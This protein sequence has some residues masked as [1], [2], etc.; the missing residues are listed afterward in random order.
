MCEY[1]SNINLHLFVP[2]KA[3]IG[4]SI[5]ML[6]QIK[7]VDSFQLQNFILKPSNKNKPFRLKSQ[8][9]HISSNPKLLTLNQIPG[10][11]LFILR[12]QLFHIIYQ[13]MSTD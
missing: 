7:Y 8:T 4:Y 13:D 6:F 12:I 2:L 10:N 9:R 3:Y 1:V 11:V 5:T